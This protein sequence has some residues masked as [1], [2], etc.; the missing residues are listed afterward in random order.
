MKVWLD[1]DIKLVTRCCFSEYRK[2]AFS[3]HKYA[4]YV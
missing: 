3:M 1:E 2:Y 4:Y